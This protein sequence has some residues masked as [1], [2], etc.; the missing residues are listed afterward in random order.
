MPQAWSIDYVRKHWRNIEAESKNHSIFQSWAWI[1]CW[2]ELAKKYVKPVIFKNSDQKIVGICFVGLGKSNDFRIFGFKT[3][4]PFITGVEKIDIV[5]SEYHSILCLPEY[6]DSI[7]EVFVDFLFSDKNLQKFKRLYLKR[8]PEDS[9]P[10]YQKASEK[11]R[12]NMDIFKKE[13]SARIDIEALQGDSKPFNTPFSK[14]CKSDIK[15]S[16]KLYNEKYGALKLEKSDSVTQAQNWFQELMKL[17]QIRFHS[18]NLK[19]AIDYPDLIQI[20]R[21]FL[22]RYFSLGKVDIVRVCCGSTAIG[23]LYNFVYNKH[24]YFYLGGLRYE[25]DNRLKPGLVTHSCAIEHYAQNNMRIYDFMA[26]DQPYKYRL[27]DD[28]PIMYHFTIT[29][30]GVKSMITQFLKR[31]KMF[32]KK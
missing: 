14:S 7:H 15:R 5:A 3:I 12:F 2:L 4:F 20:N 11:Y 1:E 6:R 17:N 26:G 27:G 28:G 25:D 24:V 19:A 31:I 13:K 9:L 32:F 8:V 30:K 21:I 29:K 22:N 16:I 10:L 23:Y 18:K